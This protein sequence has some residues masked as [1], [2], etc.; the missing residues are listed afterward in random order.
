MMFS[1]Q[2]TPAEPGSEL[3]VNVSYDCWYRPA[4]ST[5]IKTDEQGQFSLE[6]PVIKPQVIFL[7]Y[8]GQRLFLYAE[9]GKSLSIRIN[10]ME[11]KSLRFAGTLGR[12]N[13][14]RHRLGLSFNLLGSQNWNDTLSSPAEILKAIRQNQ[15]TAAE[16]LS[17]NAGSFSQACQRMTAADIR[18]F[19]A[20]KLWGLAWKNGVWTTENKSG[21]DRDA[22]RVSL[23]EAHKNLNLSDTLAL[24]SYHYQ[25][26]IAYYPRFLEYKSA[27]K[28]EFMQLAEDIFN[29][30]FAEVKEEVRQKGQ[31][32]W[33]HQALNYG[34]DGTAL[35]YALAAFLRHGIAVGELEYLQEAYENFILRFPASRYRPEVETTMKPYL[36]SLAK[37]T[38]P[39]VHLV[40]G[41][42]RIPSLDSVLAS[43]RGRV[44]YLDMWGT[45]CGPCRDEFA[46]NR[47]LKAR[48]KDLPVDFVYIAVEH[49]PTP[50][51]RWRETIAFYNLTG[52]HVLAGKELEKSLQ[53]RYAETGV[54]QFPSYIL[55]DKTGK[56]V[57]IQAPRPSEKEKLYEQIQRLL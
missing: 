25:T 43:H 12:E 17:D 36:T 11:E 50:E 46:H 47:E 18:F 8:R 45:W 55:V 56:I 6:L 4:N 35:E 3:V 26:T 44:V 15:V 32:Y 20:S 31:R 1:G 23:V 22:W 54:F 48:F 51:K 21:F 38:L 2:V 29:K 16:Q 7:D 39:G 9:P 52:E 41:S 14:L 37:T 40:P 24:D 34:L 53:D 27:S 28:D 30:P 33:E 49:S 10:S 13:E 5:Q 19:A 57:T 42:Q